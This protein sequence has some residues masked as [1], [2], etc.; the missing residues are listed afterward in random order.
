[1]MTDDH[2][3]TDTAGSSVAGKEAV[4]AAWKSFFAAF[5]DYRNEFTKYRTDLDVVVVVGR[6]ICSEPRLS[7][8][9]NWRAQVRGDKIA[10]WRV[11]D[12]TSETR[13]HLGIRS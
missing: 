12:D 1:M 8:P 7:G 4:S 3:F 11:Y 6:S 10:K 9:A 13:A 5:P 2:E